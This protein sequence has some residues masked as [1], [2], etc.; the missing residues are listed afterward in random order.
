MKKGNDVEAGSAPLTRNTVPG[1]MLPSRQGRRRRWGDGSQGRARPPASRGEKAQKPV[2][3]P[4][5]RRQAA[6]RTVLVTAP[7]SDRPRRGGTA[8]GGAEPEQTHPPEL[9]RLLHGL[10]ASAS[11]AGPH[12]P[13]HWRGATRT[14]GPDSPTQQPPKTPQLLAGATEAQGKARPE[15]GR[16]TGLLFGKSL[17]SRID[18]PH[19]CGFREWRM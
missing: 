1:E 14:R 9:T 17:P 5:V 15:E 6:R 2:S 13:C 8:V 3:Q 16:A 4:R 19:R 7:G 10:H 12:S 18:M 11:W